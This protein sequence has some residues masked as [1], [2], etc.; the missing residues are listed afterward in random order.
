MNEPEASAVPTPVIPP[1][2][3]ASPVVAHIPAALLRT[4]LE[5][6]RNPFVEQRTGQP[7]RELPIRVVAAEDG[8]FEVVDGFKRLARWKEAGHTLIPAIIESP[9]TTPELKLL[10]LRSNAPPRTA[11]PMDEARVI[12]SLVED[13]GLSLAAVAQLLGRRKPWVARRLALATRLSPVLQKK[14]EQRAIGP[15]L[16]YAFCALSD[17]GQEAVLRSIERHSLREREAL[18]LISAWRVAS[19]DRERS[20]LLADPIAVVRPQQQSSS[21]LGPAGASLHERLENIRQALSDL[22]SFHIPEQGFSD[23]ERRRLEAEYRFVLDLLSQTAQKLGRQTTLSS[24]DSQENP[25][26]QNETEEIE[27]PA[28]RASADSSAAPAWLRDPGDCPPHGSRPQS[29]PPSPPGRGPLSNNA[30]SRGSQQ[31]RSVPRFDPGQSEQTPDGHA[32]P[33]GD[34]PTGLC[35]RPHDPGQLHPIHADGV[36]PAPPSQTPL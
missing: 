10:L 17:T 20:A 24:L 18:A 21:S 13:D 9:R 19:S 16:G 26:D 34:P 28:R 14:V 35:R 22:A 25:Y 30:S 27:A 4:S 3:G 8:S 15:A 12:R 2:A 1:P 33:P 5:R 7:L 11:T 36:G 23:A 32:H 6:L 29:D 31:A